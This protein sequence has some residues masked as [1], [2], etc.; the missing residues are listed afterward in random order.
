MVIIDFPYCAASRF[1]CLYVDCCKQL[2]WFLLPIYMCC[3][4][5]FRFHLVLQDWF[6]IGWEL[7]EL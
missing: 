4:V 1:V 2:I 7:S 6:K 5:Q 3:V